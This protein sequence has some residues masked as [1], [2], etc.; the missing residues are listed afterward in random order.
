MSDIHKLSGA[1]ALDAL[2]DLERARFEDHLATCDD[3]AA[4]VAELQETAALLA[5]TTAAP[6]PASLREGVLAGISQVR[7]LPPDPVCH[8]VVRRAGGFPCW[9]PQPWSW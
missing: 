5:E 8:R 2:D 4:E 1:Y 9:W 6:A 7:P 3:C